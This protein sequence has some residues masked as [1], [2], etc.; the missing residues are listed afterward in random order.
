MR[1]GKAVSFVGPNPEEHAGSGERVIRKNIPATEP[2]Y[3]ERN[4][5][6]AEKE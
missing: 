3:S 4:M 1:F 2:V 5:P 6:A